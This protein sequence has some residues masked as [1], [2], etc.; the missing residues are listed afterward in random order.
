MIILCKIFESN[1]KM[2]TDTE[3]KMHHQLDQH[4]LHQQQ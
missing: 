1:E 4:Q 2:I 3:P